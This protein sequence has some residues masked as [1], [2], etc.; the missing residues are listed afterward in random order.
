MYIVE[1]CID[2][3]RPL[4]LH[5]INRCPVSQFTSYSSSCNG[6]VPAFFFPLRQTDYW[7]ILAER[8][9]YP[10][11]VAPGD[12]ASPDTSRLI[13]QFC[14]SVDRHLAICIMLSSCMLL[15]S[16]TV[17]F[18]TSK[19]DN[20]SLLLFR[21]CFHLVCPTTCAAGIRTGALKLLFW[22]GCFMEF[23]LWLGTHSVVEV[24]RVWPG[25][26][27]RLL[28]VPL[29]GSLALHQ[30]CKTLHVHAVVMI[31]TRYGWQSC[32]W[33]FLSEKVRTSSHFISL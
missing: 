7:V 33:L 10:F 1:Q 5:L 28:I 23:C 25:R 17:F 12:D 3:R 13:L 11:G 22:L 20:L 30:L 4:L 15:A 8:P 32:H 2:S 19:Y 14:F 24:C 26:E 21:L 29:L 27:D 31:V 9:M 16:A 6:K 18:F